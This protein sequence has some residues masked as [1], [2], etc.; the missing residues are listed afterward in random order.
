MSTAEA[1]SAVDFALAPLRAAIS[2]PAR[3]AYVSTALFFSTSLVLL[4]LA[5]VAYILFYFSY[6]PKIGIE[7]TVHLQF[8]AGNPY[9]V[10]SLGESLVGQQAYDVTVHL[11]LPRSPP[12]LAAGNFM[13]DLALLSPGSA[14][15]MVA[16]TEDDVL[17]R[18]RR[19]AILTYVSPL[20][21]KASKAGSVAWILLGLHR[22]AEQLRVPMLEGVEFA[23]GWRNVPRALKLEVQS[24]EKMGVYSVRV[25]FAARF[26]GLRWIMHK[27]RILSLLLFVSAFYSTSIISTALA[28][29]LLSVYLQRDA[30]G[31][32]IKRDPDGVGGSDNAYI[33]TEES[34]S[35]ALD[36]SDTPR[37]FPTY[38]RQPPL[39]F[40]SPSGRAR[41]GEDEG[42][43]RRAPD[44]DDADGVGVD[45][46]GTAGR[47][48]DSGIGTSL[49]EGVGGLQRRR[50]RGRN[51]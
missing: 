18:S 43:G 11:D 33:K 6:L 8:G 37:S 16:P 26:T 22:E 38:A 21:D 29:V 35:D 9:G 13:L 48:T 30:G 7:R 44:E 20:V 10:V 46:A 34:E 41:G 15:Y 31:G 12:N 40:R 47:R 2:K 42:G 39:Q 17:V 28:W 3:R 50:S 45:V 19:P 14:T 23:R 36:L 25:V 5:V 27:H 51:A 24:D 1:S 4:G 49:E 32:G